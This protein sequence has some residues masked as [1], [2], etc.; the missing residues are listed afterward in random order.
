[1]SGGLKLTASGDSG[2]ALAEVYDATLPGTYAPAFPRLVNISA[3]VKVSPGGNALIAGFVIGGETS[4]TVL[5]RVSG[6][7]LSAF[8]LTGVLPDPQLQLFRSNADGTS[9]IVQTDTDWGGDSQISAT[10]A[11]VGAFSW[12]TAE[13]PDS[14]I[15]VT[16]PAGAYTAEVIGASRD[17]GIALVEVYE[18]Q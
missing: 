3:R 18:I 12:G 16:L 7:A 5:I 4:E 15:L 14:E 9:T 10:A 6:P 17:A 1:M 13:T 8:G 2:I 11:A